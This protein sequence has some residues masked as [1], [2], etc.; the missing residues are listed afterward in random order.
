MSGDLRLHA[1]ALEE[2]A[3]P[4]LQEEVGMVGAHPVPSPS[5]NGQLNRET[6]ILWELHHRISLL[7]PKC[8]E[9]VAF[10]NIVRAIPQDSAVDE[11]TIEVLLRLLGYVVV[12]TPRSIVYNRGP[13]TV[14]DFLLQRRRVQAGHQWVYEKYNYP[15][16]TMKATAVFRVAA[17]YLA[18]HPRDV[19]P[20]ARLM[21][22]EVVARFLGL[23][24]YYL[25]GKNPYVW[26][27]VKR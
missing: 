14:Q 16:V 12:Y 27:M 24:D 20:L 25:L 18:T 26:Q 19:W 15:V 2:I 23:V 7:Q 1:K 6:A 10:R 22:L 17:A 3:L 13:K 9:M 11:A 5:R 8:G 21:A 4:F